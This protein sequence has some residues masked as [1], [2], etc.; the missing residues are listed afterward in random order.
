MHGPLLRLRC[1]VNSYAWGKK[2]NDSCAARYAAATAA[3]SIKPEQPYAELWMGTHPSNPSYDV[4]TSQTLLQI[5][6]EED[7]LLSPSIVAQY[8]RELPF[9]FKI[10]SI[11]D[12][13]SIQAHPDKI[14]AKQLHACDPINYPDENHKPE[15]AIAVTPF[16]ALCGFRPLD[17]ITHFLE[18]VPTLRALVGE[19]E[20]SYFQTAAAMYDK[21]MIHDAREADKQ[22]LHR[23]FSKLMNSSQSSIA[24]ASKAL[25]ESA[26]IEGDSFAGGGVTSTS[27]AVLSE[28]IVRLYGQFGPDH[29][30][31]V[32]FFTNFVTL[33]PGGALYLQADDIH[34]YI[35][36]D[37]V[38]CMA[39][40]DNVVRAG[41]TARFKDVPTLVDMLTYNYAPIEEQVMKPA[42]YLEAALN[43]KAASN[44]SF[45]TIYDPPI[46]EFA[47]ARSVLKGQGA[48]ATYHH[49]NGPS[50]IICTSGE[51]SITVGSITMDVQ[52]GY[53]FFV[54]AAAE[55]AL[56]AQSDNEDF[57]MYRAFCEIK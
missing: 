50:I 32:L 4:S 49:M 51:G 6:K 18:Q 40:S 2:G 10:L 26:K 24:S 57:E 35:S 53:V 19:D 28:L 54:G 47:V 45:I 30:L 42:Q 29:G 44:G 14:L 31:F 36:G 48:A 23:A 22:A 13:L 39:T 17:E 43:E 1:G 25:V 27:G 21:N 7:S 56:E 12:A 37:I 41:F 16:E 5:I 9:L 8:G 20:S 15:M 55:C 52:E 46:D 34:A 3:F 38:E 33:P 11:Q